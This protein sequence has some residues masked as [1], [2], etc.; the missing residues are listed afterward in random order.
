MGKAFVEKFD[1]VVWEDNPE[2]FEAWKNGRTG[3]PIVDAAMRAMK[4][5]GYMHVSWVSSC[6]SGPR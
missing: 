4:V 3:F 6:P 2:G 5:Q 1:S